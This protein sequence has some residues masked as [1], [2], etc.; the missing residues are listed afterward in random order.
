MSHTHAK[1]PA[2]D[3]PAREDRQVLARLQELLEKQRELVHQGRLAAAAELFDETERCVQKI[4][5]A[6]TREVPGTADQ[7]Q[8]IERL[9]RQLCLALAVQRTETGAALAAIRRGRQMLRTYGSCTEGFP[10]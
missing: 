9:Y 5:E 4:A 6:R 7:W 1:E 8:C 3:V 2:E 10:R